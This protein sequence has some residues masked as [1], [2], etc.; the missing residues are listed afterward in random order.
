M[1]FKP[2]WLP[3][4]SSNP[5]TNSLSLIPPLQEPVGGGFNL[6]EFFAD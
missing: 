5:L 6:K 4:H 3:V 1:R 2:L